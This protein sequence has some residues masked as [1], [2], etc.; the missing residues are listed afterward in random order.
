MACTWQRVFWAIHNLMQIYRFCMNKC[1][2]EKVLTHPTQ[3]P[4]TDVFL[5]FSS[6][7]ARPVVFSHASL[8]LPAS[9]PNAFHSNSNMMK[10]T[11]KIS[12]HYCNVASHKLGKR[13]SACVILKNN[14]NFPMHLIPGELGFQ[15]AC[16]SGMTC[17]P[18]Q[19][20]IC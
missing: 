5:K 19:L 17:A 13:A 18:Q 7:S 12:Y 4:Y 11:H 1:P 14:K 15:M 16:L 10:Q 20:P 6:R 8:H 3:I 9:L 2:S